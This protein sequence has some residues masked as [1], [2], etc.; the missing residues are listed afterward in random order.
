MV[1][2]TYIITSFTKIF[3]MRN[4][5][6]KNMNQTNTISE[7]NKLLQ[8]F[9][10]KQNNY[11]KLDQLYQRIQILY[12]DKAKRINVNTQYLAVICLI[13]SIIVNA[14]WVKFIN[15]FTSNQVPELSA[16][17]KNI[18]DL[19]S[20]FMSLVFSIGIPTLIFLFMAFLIYIASYKVR[21]FVYDNFIKKSYMEMLPYVRDLCAHYAKYSD[22]ASNPPV[23]NSF[24]SCNPKELGKIH[25][26]LYNQEATT[27][28][29]A[30]MIM[31]S[32]GISYDYSFIPKSFELSISPKTKRQQRAEYNN[33]K[34]KAATSTEELFF[35]R[36]IEDASSLKKRYYELMKI[37]HTDGSS[38]DTEMTQKVID[39]YQ[40]VKKKF[41][42]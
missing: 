28:P 19:S 34:K 31:R 33:Q 11:D 7:L 16:A 20:V 4:N 2:F 37:Y 35:F 10:E 14:K 15:H 30:K 3:K 1:R 12:R 13:L 21:D 18:T 42:D 32:L 38:G 29:E 26:I 17:L 41:E 22:T 27:I 23:I 5:E 9:I 36:G 8:H 6:E 40:T 24:R 39:E 25:Q